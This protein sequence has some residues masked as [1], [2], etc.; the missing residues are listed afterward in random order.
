MGKV[1]S[2]HDAYGEV[3][4][5][6]S[7]YVS[8]VV[9]TQKDGR[10]RTAVS[11]IGKDLEGKVHAL[12]RER[13]GTATTAPPIGCDS[14]SEKAVRFHTHPNGSTEPSGAD[15]IGN[16]IEVIEVDCIGTPK[17]SYGQIECRVPLWSATEAIRRETKTCA[18]EVHNLASLYAKN[19]SKGKIEEANKSGEDLR[20]K[21]EILQKH[22]QS[23]FSSV[24]VF[25][26]HAGVVS[27]NIPTWRQKSDT[28]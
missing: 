9:E 27:F 1:F 7:N 28:Q 5:Q 16:L 4:E 22:V 23:T 19:L 3:A 24:G 2:R 20:K 17:G 14:E 13:K 11:C 15:I 6:F 10:E 18:E 21:I 26:T 8:K 12:R 25:P